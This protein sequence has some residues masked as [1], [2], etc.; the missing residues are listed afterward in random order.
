MLESGQITQDIFA[1]A[2][3]VVL[4]TTLVTPIILRALYRGSS[5]AEGR[6]KP[7]EREGQD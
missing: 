4:A 7:S 2:V 5:L 6:L 3:L 1:S